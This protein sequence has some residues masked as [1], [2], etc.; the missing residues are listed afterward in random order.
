MK[1]RNPIIIAAGVSV[2]FLTILS[3]FA[4]GN[5]TPSGAPAPTMKSLDQ[6]EPRIPISYA[7]YTITSPGSYYVIT[8]LTGFNSGFSHGIT[9]SSGNVTIDLNGFTLQGTSGSSS[10]IYISGDY[11][12][13]IVR[14]GIV[15]GWGGNGV[16]WNYP[17]LPAPQNIVVEHLTVS[18]NYNGIVT[19]NGGLVSDCLVENNQIGGILV[20]G[21]GSQII[22]NILL[23]N[24][25]ANNSSSW[26]I[27]VQGSNNRIEGNHITGSGTSG[28]GINYS[29]GGYTNNIIIRNSVE[30][31]GAN[32]YSTGS[33]VVNDV[34]PIG[35][36][37]TNTSP[38]GNISH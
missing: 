3:G 2:L 19:A 31:G 15:T 12:N 16:S 25:P 18:G 24:N 22:G 7:G 10:G 38:W 23:G 37:S 13:V 27:A 26:G 8:N 32:N 36:A 11:T 14:N 29:F 6:V 4:Q 34:G 28:Y 5:L 30:G 33:G 9:I 35:N 17:N 20:D 21:N 1:I